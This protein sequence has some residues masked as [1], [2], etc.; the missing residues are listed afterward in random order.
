MSRVSIRRAD[1]LPILFY[2]PLLAP[3]HGVCD[4][5]NL[6]AFRLILD[7]VDLHDGLA[8]NPVDLD[9]QSLISLILRDLGLV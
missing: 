1:P 5:V 2:A 9:V 6:K 7:H 4:E 8:N 3:L